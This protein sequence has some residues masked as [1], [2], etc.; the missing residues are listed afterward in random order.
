MN[1][2]WTHNYSIFINEESRGKVS[3]NIIRESFVGNESN[4]IV[5]ALSASIRV[6]DDSSVTIIDNQIVNSKQ[7]GICIYEAGRV[8]IKQT[9]ID[10]VELYGILIC[11]AKSILIR[12]N[13]IKNCRQSSIMMFSYSNATVEYNTIFNIGKYAFCIICQSFMEAKENVIDNVKCFVKLNYKG[14]GDFI[15]N[16][17]SN[18]NN[19]L[20]AETSSFYFLSVNGNFPNATNNKSRFGDSIHIDEFKSEIESEKNQMCLKCK[21]NKRDCIL[22]NLQRMH[23]R[24]SR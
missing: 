5:N 23:T 19:Q 6:Q 18:C 17:V 12:S 15:N 13:T 7:N 11:R 9:E 1:Y 24:C 4:H 20:D 16:H 3:N 14:G 8:E 22:F 2:I 10:I 21:K